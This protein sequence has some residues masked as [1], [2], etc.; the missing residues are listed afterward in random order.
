[1]G[2]IRLTVATGD[3]D[4]LR[5][6]TSGEVKAEG[7]DITH[8]KLHVLEIFHRF[9]QFREFDVSEMSM[10]RHISL[11][12]QGKADHVAIPVFPSRVFRLSAFYIRSDGKVKR[13]E[14]L[15]GKKVGVPEWAQ[16]ATIYGRGWLSDYIGVD[17]KSIQ[18]FQAGQD[19]PGRVEPV[20]LHLPPGLKVTP[21]PDRSLNDML[22]AGDIDALIAAYPP[23]AFR[24][25][26]PKIARL[27][28]DARAA[29]MKYWD[30]TGIFPIMHTIVI[31]R[32]VCA[33]N[34]WVPMSLFKAFDKAKNNSLA[35]AGSFGGSLYPLPMHGYWADEARK[36]LGED[37][38]PY[39]VEA[40]RKTLEAF[41]KFAHDQ[42]VAHRL[43]A[44]DEL[45]A[46]QVANPYRV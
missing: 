22:L 45:F 19:D 21:V 20:A 18:W 30:D 3:Y 37:F 9:T 31:R 14:D 39:G 40:S 2:N 32:E 12:S 10:G 23:G 44:P 33:A 35:R 11:V 24:Q 41:A 15:A 6:F 7:I 29:E 26:N 5:D 46:P 17:L 16:T 4:H 38:W 42:G 27:V 36:R 25:R 43:V 28:A 34:P 8:L 13:P 1:M